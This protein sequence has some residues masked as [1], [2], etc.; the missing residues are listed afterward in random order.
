MSVGCLDPAG[1]TRHLGLRRQAAGR[2][3]IMHDEA[4]LFGLNP[5][6]AARP[7]P[8]QIQARY[9]RGFTSLVRRLGADP[10]RILER[11][12]IDPVAVDD[13]DHSLECSNMANMLEYCSTY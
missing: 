5:A 12:E 11:F 6:L 10:R 4:F 3:C 1:E 2:G 8:G 13:P 7:A 9:L